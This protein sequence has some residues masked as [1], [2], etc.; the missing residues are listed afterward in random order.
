MADHETKKSVDESRRKFLET[1][2]K[3]AAA[4]PAAALLLALDAKVANAQAVPYQTPGTIGRDS[5]AGT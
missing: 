4:A 1:A 3:T 5:P 2:G